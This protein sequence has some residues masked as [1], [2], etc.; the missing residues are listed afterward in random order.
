VVYDGSALYYAEVIETLDP[1]NS[2]STEMRERVR[3]AAHQSAQNAISRGDL[4]QAQ[5]VY[6]F[7]VDNYEDD[8]E[9]R[10]AAAKLE[11]QL[12]RALG[13]VRELV[14]KA[15]EALLASRLTE[16]AGKSAYFYS[17]QALAIDRQNESPT[18][19]NQVKER[20]TAAGEQALTW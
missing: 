18:D 9:A 11:N 4:G 6:K 14:R 1:R 10:A 20:L 13:Q 12:A 2:F 5:E 17:K 19:S 8:L 15:D 3:Q 16:L 7:L